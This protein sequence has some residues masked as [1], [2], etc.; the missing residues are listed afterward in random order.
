MTP[1]RR[2]EIEALLCSPDLARHAPQV[3]R[4]LLA[5]LD[6]VTA[7]ASISLQGDS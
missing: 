2:A 4:E 3:I 6:R 1:A 5:E 7:G